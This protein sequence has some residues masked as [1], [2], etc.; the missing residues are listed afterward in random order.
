MIFR[1]GSAPLLPGLWL[2]GMAAPQVT[3]ADQAGSRGA[4]V[5]YPCVHVCMCVFILGMYVCMYVYMYTKNCSRKKHLLPYTQTRMYTR[6]YIAAVGVGT[7][8]QTGL[9]SGLKMVSSG[10]A[11]GAYCV[12]EWTGATGRGHLQFL[13]KRW[14]GV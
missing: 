14:A 4:R 1:H 12:N 7:M 3:K 13:G 2:L 10:G 6:I 11:E 5:S 9:A 8:R